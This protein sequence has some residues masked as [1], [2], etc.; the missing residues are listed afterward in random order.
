MIDAYETDPLPGEIFK[1]I[2][3]NGSL[4]EITIA[5]CTEQDGKIQ[6]RG[7]CFVPENDQVQLQSIQEHYDTALAGHPD[8]AKRFDL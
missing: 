2:L 4:K 5:E 6:Y 3:T 7:R 1:V 8:R